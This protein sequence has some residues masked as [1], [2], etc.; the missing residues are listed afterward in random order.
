LTIRHVITAFALFCVLGPARGAFTV[1]PA[2]IYLDANTGERTAMLEIKNTG[3]GPVAVELVLF[4]R[5]LDLDGE[6]DMKALVPNKDFSIYPSEIILHPGKRANV[7]LMYKDKNKV[8]ADKAYFLFSKEVLMPIEMEEKEDVNIVV[9]T[10]MSYYT[11]VAFETGKEGKL[12]FVSS[13]LI[14]DGLA[15]LIV[16]NKGNGRA[17]VKNL[18]IKTSTDII[19]GFSGVKNSIMPGQKRRFTFKYI[20]P[21]TAGEVKF[22]YE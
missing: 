3:K 8:T 20:R 9:P 11:I 1:E 17:V 5:V 21:L 4:E 13:K 14:Q 15:E 12:A 7:Q 6:P 10:V 18:A 19:R 16:E 22:I 2:S